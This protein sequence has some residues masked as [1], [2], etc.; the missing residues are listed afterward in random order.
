MLGS[1]QSWKD[2]VK[3]FINFNTYA[4]AHGGYEIF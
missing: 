2:V 4:A 1:N 3:D